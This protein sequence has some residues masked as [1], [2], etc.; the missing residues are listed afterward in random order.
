MVRFYAQEDCF[1][2][3]VQWEYEDPLLIAVLYWGD[4]LAF[5]THLRV[6]DFF[7]RIFVDYSASE[8]LRRGAG[9]WRVYAFIDSG[10]SNGRDCRQDRRN[11]DANEGSA[12]RCF[13]G[14]HDRVS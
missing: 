5:Q 12:A 10:R 14:L 6:S 1:V 9:L 2:R 11:D 8:S 7:S 4:T 3:V 13:G